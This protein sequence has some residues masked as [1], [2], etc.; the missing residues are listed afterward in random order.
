MEHSNEVIEV[1]D[2]EECRAR[3]KGSKYA[4]V[5]FRYSEIDGNGEDSTDSQTAAAEESSEEE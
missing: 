2:L 3:L 1:Q 4:R 5:N